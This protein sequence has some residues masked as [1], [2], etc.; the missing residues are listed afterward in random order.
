MEKDAGMDEDERRWDERYREKAPAR[1]HPPDALLDR[2]DLLQLVPA[3]GCALDIACGTGAQTLWLALRGLHV[4]ALDVS[5]VALDLVEQG[6]A[7]CGVGPQVATRRLDVD[8]GLPDDLTEFD[9][10]VCQRFRDPR[11]YPTIIDRLRPEGMAIVT[12]LSAVGV[13]GPAGTFHAPAGEL[14]TAFTRDG[15]EMIDTREGDGQA[16]VVVRRR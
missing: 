3:E 8:G 15:I 14:V 13:E 6:A 7:S 1:P 12:V 5:G 9:V 11:L 10:I 16:S 2:G 4:T